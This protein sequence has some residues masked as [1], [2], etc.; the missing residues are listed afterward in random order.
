MITRVAHFLRVHK[1]V[2]IISLETYNMHI[3]TNYI[4]LYHIL[5]LYIH[6]LRLPN[7]FEKL[8]QKYDEI[9]FPHVRPLICFRLF[10]SHLSPCFSFS[11]L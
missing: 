2:K 6:K 5:K 11:I 1:K 7:I 8:I 9:E 10:L 3:F 4:S